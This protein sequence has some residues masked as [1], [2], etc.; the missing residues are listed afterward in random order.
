MANRRSP[1]SRAQYFPSGASGG[2]VERDGLQALLT[3]LRDG[4][5]DALVVYKADQLSRSLRDLLNLID[6]VLKP[7]GA[8]FVSVTEQFDTTTAQGRLFI[9]MVGSLA[10]F[11]RNIITERL[12]KGRRSKPLQGGDAAGEI[13]FGGVGLTL[14]NYTYPE[15]TP[16]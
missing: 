13:L 4:A 15:T 1:A 3:A 8:A 5:H 11:E 6:D 12:T 7:E 14:T 16:I 9:Q 2:T 10:E